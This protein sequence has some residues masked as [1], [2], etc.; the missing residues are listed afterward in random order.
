MLQRPL[1]TQVRPR[2]VKE[3]DSLQYTDFNRTLADTLA[4]ENI[5]DMQAIAPGEY[6]KNFRLESL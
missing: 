3:M 4:I 2:N 5:L 6:R 1:G